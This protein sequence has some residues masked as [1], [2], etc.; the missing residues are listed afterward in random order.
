MKDI[1]K[2]AEQVTIWFGRGAKD[3]NIVMSYM[4]QVHKTR[5]LEKIC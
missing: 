1:H 4:Y 3:I 2:E 5:R